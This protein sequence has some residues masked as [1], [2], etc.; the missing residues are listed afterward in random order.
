MLTARVPILDSVKGK[1]G[2][3][4]QLA[5]GGTDATIRLWD[6]ATGTPTAAPLTRSDTGT[7]AA[8]TPDGRLAPPTPLD[9]NMPLAP[10]VADPSRLCDNLSANMNHQQWRDWVSP[11]IGYIKVCP[12]LPGPD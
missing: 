6:T 7:D 8:T 11:G 1:P 10:A 4:H 3:S 5:S 9:G 2:P 12:G